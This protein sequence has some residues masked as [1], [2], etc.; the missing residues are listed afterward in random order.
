MNIFDIIGPVMIGPSSSHTAGAVRIGRVSRMILGDIVA[1]AEIGLAGSFA[2]TG[3]GHGTDRALLAGLMDMDTDDDRIKDSF[4]VANE[5]GLEYHFSEVK[6]PRCHPNTVK[7]HLTGKTGKVC[8]VQGSS[9]GGGNIIITNVNE[10][11]TE[12]SGSVDTLIIAHKDMPGMIA[13]VSSLM[14]EHDVNIGNFR[15]NRP[16]KGFQAVMTVEIDG[17]MDREL[18]ANLRAMPHI[19][20]VVYLRAHQ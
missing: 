1:R 17:A 4:T 2:Q 16:H 11:E 18:I 3:R 12:F 9:V 10:M 19:D 14:A 15:L 13:A 20:S 7:L 6:I 5:Q 8:A